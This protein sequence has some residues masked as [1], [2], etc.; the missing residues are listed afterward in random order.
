MSADQILIL[1]AAAF[2]ASRHHGQVRKWTGEPYVTHTLE[3]AAIVAQVTDDVDM[4]VAA[5]L[6]DVVEDTNTQIGEVWN[7]FGYE[8]ADHVQ[9]LTDVSKLSDGNRAIRKAM[10]RE[11]IAKAPPRTKTIKL[12][13]LISNSRSI[14]AL[15]EGFARIYLP[16]KAALLEVL[17]EG[18][19]SLWQEA[20][21]IVQQGL[22]KLAEKRGA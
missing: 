6:H 14:L 17:T 11:H 4:I 15:D 5:I 16:E 18:D 12:A 13:D 20:Q 10:D 19:L 22:F 2:A 1:E 9:W 21:E 3:V 7:R 8:V